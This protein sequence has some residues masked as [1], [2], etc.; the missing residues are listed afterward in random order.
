M[1]RQGGGQRR[2]SDGLLCRSIARGAF[3]VLGSIG[4][5]AQLPN[6]HRLLKRH[7]IDVDVLTAGQYKR[8]LTV[9]GE[10]TEEGRE[11]FLAELNT[12]HDLFKRYV[13][14]RRPDLDIEA[15]ATGEAGMARRHCPG[16]W[17][18][19]LAPARRIL[20]SA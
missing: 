6:V 12:V 15:V 2:L 19:R 17:S 14:E 20:P 4:V 1:C 18:T 11:K 10:N 16:G 3:A 9:F 7:D 8:T 5:V 13:A